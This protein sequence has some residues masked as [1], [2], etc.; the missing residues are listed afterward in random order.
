MESLITLDDRGRMVPTD[1]AALAESIAALLDGPLAQPGPLRQAGVGLLVLG[2]HHEAVR[3]LERAL[4]LADER[5][6][7][8]V[9]INLGDARRYRGD[10]AT[11]EPHYQEALRLAHA[12]APELLYHCFQ[13]LGKQRLEQG[14]TVEAR[15]L[16]DE[17]MRRI[18]GD[19]PLVAATATA[20]RL[21]DEADA[22][23]GPPDGGGEVRP[24]GRS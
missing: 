10:P 8:A 20:L 14:R 21:A 1:R 11:A 22:A 24:A 17:A 19:A 16:L 13:H 6:A 12:H 23:A 18:D 5:R 2:R 3:V 4:A 9:H 7:V 15:T